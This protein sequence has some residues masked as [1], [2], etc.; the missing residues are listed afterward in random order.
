MGAALKGRNAAVQLLVDRGAR[1]EQRDRGSRDTDKI[2]S[3]AAGYTWEALD[4]A[5]GLVRV[6]VQ[7]ATAY[8]ETAALIRRLLKE[9]GLPVP[10]ENRN[11]L[12]ICVVSLCQ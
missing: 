2:G 6:G 9:R 4:Y 11:I 12:S 1:L 5:E 10:P 3:A 7:S 8:P